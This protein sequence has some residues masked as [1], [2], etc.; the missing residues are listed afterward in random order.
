MQDHSPQHWYLYYPNAMLLVSLCLA[1]VGMAIRNARRKYALAGFILVTGLVVSASVYMRG[2]AGLADRLSVLVPQTRVYPEVRED[3]PE[4]IRLLHFLARLQRYR[5]GPIYVLSSSETLSYTHLRD[6][7][8]S[9]TRTPLAP[10]T[11][12]WC[13]EVDRRD[14]FPRNLLKAQY[15]LVALPIQYHLRP[16]DQRVIGIPARSF[17]AH[18]NIGNAFRQMPD[19]FNLR[20]GVKLAVFEKTRAISAAELRDLVEIFCQAYPDWRGP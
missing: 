19:E 4:L 13:S 11:I 17:A 3:M 18:S 9:L 16:Q 15:V 7:Y 10:G 8:L 14:G 20:N 2:A 6:A 5:P 12:L 1:Q